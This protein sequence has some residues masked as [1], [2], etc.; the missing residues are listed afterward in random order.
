MGRGR[1]RHR[2]GGAGHVARPRRAARARPRP[3]RRL[4]AAEE[5]RP[6]STSC[7]ATPAARCSRPICA[8]ALGG[9][10]QGGLDERR[11]GG[12]SRSST[13]P[14]TPPTSSA[15]ST[16]TRPSGSR[17]CATTA[18]WSGPAMVARNF[19]MPARAGTRRAA[20]HR[21]RPGAHPA[22]PHR[23]ARADA[24]PAARGPAG[25]AR[26]ADHRPAHAQRAGRLRRPVGPGASSSC[27]AAVG[28]PGRAS[29]TCARCRDP[30]GLLVELIEYA[31]RGARQPD[32]RPR[33]AAVVSGRVARGTGGRAV[34]VDPAV[35]PV[36]RRRRTRCAQPP[37]RRA[38]RV[39]RGPGARRHRRL[40][41]SAAPG[42]SRGRQPDTGPAPHAAGRRRARLSAGCRPRPTSSVWRSTA[43]RSRT[44]T[45]SA[46]S[47]STGRMYN[48]FPASDVTSLG[49]RRNSIEP[50]A[51][52]IVGRGV[53]LDI[54]RLRGVELARAR[55]RRQARRAR[56]RV[57][58]RKAVEV[59]PGRHPPGVD[60]ARRAT[61]RARAVG[62]RTAPASPG[63]TPSA[64]R[65][66]TSATV[67]VLGSDGVSDV[68]PA[69]AHAWPMPLHMC[70]L[71]GMGVHLLDNLQLERL[72]EACDAG[73]AVGVPVHGLRRC[74]SGAAR[75]PR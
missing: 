3:P 47:S 38:H 11:L 27:R 49:A 61:G 34:R 30:D 5:R 36:G 58:A 65:G 10:G 22:R 55:R 17:S 16:S 64:C 24:R 39:G 13:S 41:R 35:G 14:S 45:R 75:A 29:S 28:A 52:G 6:S 9:H 19:G 4:Q 44:S 7:R 33:T 15:R 56:R 26:A 53:L 48:G 31:A 74:T 25:A 54:P 68:L 60:R 2:R 40:V 18:T 71:V 42:G 37:D 72:A 8:A 66:C 70:L 12:S 67:A 62:S 57:R 46:T 20:R 23:V 63:S 43:W 50:A 51:D 73:R 21:R 69:N 59:G 32:R 1:A